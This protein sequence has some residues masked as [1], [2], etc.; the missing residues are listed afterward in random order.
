[1]REQTHAHA[2]ACTWKFTS[3]KY[4]IQVRKITDALFNVERAIFFS[5][6]VSSVSK[7]EM[8]IEFYEHV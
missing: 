3:N 6:A 7:R 4:F 2:Y 5:V 1:M 8:N